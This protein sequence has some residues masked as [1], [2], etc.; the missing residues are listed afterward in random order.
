MNRSVVFGA[1]LGCFP[2]GPYCE[3]FPATRT[4]PR[5][6][7][8]CDFTCS[9][10]PAYRFLNSGFVAAR[11]PD[12]RAFFALYAAEFASRKR[13]PPN[14]DQ[15]ISAEL[16]VRH[17]TARRYG[18]DLEAQLSLQLHRMKRRSLEVSADG[19]VASRLFDR[20]PA[21]FLHFNGG[22]K[23]MQTLL[24]RPAGDSLTAPG[25]M[26]GMDAGRDGPVTVSRALHSGTPQQARLGY[27]ESAQGVGD[28]QAG[29]AGSWELT[30]SETAD[31]ATARSA[32]Q[33]RCEACGRCRYMSFSVLWKDC[34]WHHMCD[35]KALRRDVRGFLT[36]AVRPVSRMKLALFRKRKQAQAKAAAALAAEDEIRFAGNASQ[37]VVPPRSAASLAMWS[38]G[39]RADVA[40]TI[41]VMTVLLKH[42][43]REEL[44]HSWPAHGGVAACFVVSRWLKDSTEGVVRKHGRILP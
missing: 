36:V 22:S 23:F 26:G 9:N 7:V 34:T 35:L 43:R 3:Q 19:S 10:P 31:L 30:A 5:R 29:R 40:L 16:F 17:H 33:R 39:P 18:L 14:P 8:D 20:K 28:C 11:V 6:L 25:G 4:V 42:G 38:C 37:D 13:I 44:R 2:F 15:A 41:G 24:R 21:C 12:A 27:C 32:C 1:E